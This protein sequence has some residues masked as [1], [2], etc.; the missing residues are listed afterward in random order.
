MGQ[1]LLAIRYRSQYLREIGIVRWQ[2]RA[3]RTS[4]VRADGD[5]IELEALA[6]KVRQCQACGLHTHRQNTVFGHGSIDADWLFVGEA[7][8]S[9]EDKIGRAAGRERV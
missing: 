8:G 4:P 3:S 5:G 2:R 1:Q 9:E 6:D 7:P